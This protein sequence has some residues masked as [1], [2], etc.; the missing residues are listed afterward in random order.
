[1]PSLGDQGSQT[2]AASKRGGH[3]LIRTL[4]V[5]A[6]LCALL[7]SSALG[8]RRGCHTSGCDRR[9][10]QRYGARHPL[11]TALA[12]EYGYG[13]GQLG[14]GL[15]CGGRYTSLAMRGVANRTLRC[16]TRVRLCLKRCVTA[17]VV[18]RGPYAGGRD[19]DLMYQTAR[20]LGVRFPWSGTIRWRV[21]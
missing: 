6:A 13:D 7:T 10:A 14:G 16:G 15:A 2:R 20:D 18:D 19:F 4:I 21:L 3:A 8:H 11:S 12:S 5:V 9:A 1:M 17:R